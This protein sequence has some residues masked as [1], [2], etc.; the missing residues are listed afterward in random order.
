MSYLLE[1]A[2]KIEQKYQTDIRKLYRIHARRARLLGIWAAEK[3]YIF[4]D[5]ATDYA[6]TIVMADHAQP[7]GEGMRKKIEVDFQ[8]NEIAFDVN[9]YAEIYSKLLIRAE[10]EVLEEQDIYA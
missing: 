1:D 2:K 8:N 9:E 6:V 5:K 3:M 4:G 10:S 7:D